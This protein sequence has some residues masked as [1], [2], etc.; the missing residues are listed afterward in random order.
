MQNA[1]HTEI[2]I[3][4]DRKPAGRAQVGTRTVAVL[5]ETCSAATPPNSKQMLSK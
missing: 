3:D 1:V 5:P 4:D 2:A